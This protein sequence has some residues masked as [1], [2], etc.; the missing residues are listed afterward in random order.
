MRLADG[1]SQYSSAH[2]PAEGVCRV[3]TQ[4]RFSF[5]SSMDS[6]SG[7]SVTSLPGDVI[8]ATPDQN[9]LDNWCKLALDS[10]PLVSE[11]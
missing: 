6:G 9:L 4:S 3:K 11:L 2:A 7:A 10:S 5:E 1:E 8:Q